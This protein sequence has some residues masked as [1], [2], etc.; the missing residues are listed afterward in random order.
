M[1]NGVFYK[2][3]FRMRKVSDFILYSFLFI[4]SARQALSFIKN[5]FLVSALSP[6][7]GALPE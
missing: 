2:F 7:R 1:Y 4:L 3:T 5:P 6:L